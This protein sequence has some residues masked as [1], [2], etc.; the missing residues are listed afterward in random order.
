MW[1]FIIILCVEVMIFG[2]G[3]YS[4]VTKTLSL[5]SYLKFFIY[6]DDVDENGGPFCYVEG[7]HTKKFEIDKR[8][9]NEQYSWSTDSIEEIYGKDKVK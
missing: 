1:F 2:F 7:S 6:L 8:N 9:W 4:S 3:N 5:S